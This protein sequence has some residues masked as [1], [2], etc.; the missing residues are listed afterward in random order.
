[1]ADNRYRNW[2]TIL[3]PESAK[4][5]WEEILSELKSP[6]LISPLHDQDVN[7][8][9]EKKKP[10]YHILF[11]Y[12]GKK[13][14]EQIKE[15]TDSIGAVG[16]EAVNSLR[17]YARYLTHKDNPEK[18]QYNE[19]GVKCLGGIDYQGIIGLPTDRRKIFDELRYFIKSNKILAFADLAD[20]AA[21][22][23][24]DWFDVIT[25]SGTLFLKEYIKS[26]HWRMQY[27]GSEQKREKTN[28]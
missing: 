7:P 14:R 9:G 6:I 17:G 24:P 18:Y 15:I 21:E 8:G 26:N 1:M 5:N 11:T 10:H 3:Y 12:E 23:R 19:Q 27:N 22:N 2:A 20:Y 4:E 28:V 13:S 16:Q 25:V